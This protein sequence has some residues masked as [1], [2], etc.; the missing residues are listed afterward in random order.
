M[1]HCSHIDLNRQW[2]AE[3][4]FGN[5]LIPYNSTHYIMSEAS[6]AE[7]AKPAEKPVEKPRLTSEADVTKYKVGRSIIFPSASNKI[8]LP[9]LRGIL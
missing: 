8:Y 4:T 5:P 3:R 7:P 2:V 1:E 9:R 6:K